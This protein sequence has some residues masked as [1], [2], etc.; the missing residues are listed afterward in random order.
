MGGNVPSVALTWEI[1]LLVCSYLLASS[2]YFEFSP[3]LSSWESGIY[4]N[5][6]DKLDLSMY[7]FH[8]KFALIMATKM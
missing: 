4:L 8:K 2:K 1:F 7:T 5:F 3:T 6:S